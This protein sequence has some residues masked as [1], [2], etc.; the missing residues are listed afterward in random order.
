MVY[1]LLVFLY[2]ES[3]PYCYVMTDCFLL[4]YVQY[5]LGILL[6]PALY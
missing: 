3:I 1:K 2:F 4:Q 5:I 6:T